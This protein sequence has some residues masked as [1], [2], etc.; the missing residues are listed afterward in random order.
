MQLT[1]YSFLSSRLDHIS[2]GTARKVAMQ[3]ISSGNRLE[4]GKTD[5]GA[6]SASL[7]LRSSQLEMNR[8]MG[9][10]QNA[11][12]FLQT[13]EAAIGS[14]MSI[15]DR[16][17]ELKTLFEDPTKS[18]SDRMFY[19]EEFKEISGQ[20]E[21]LK[22]M[23][24]NK[25]SLFSEIGT[26]QGLYGGSVESF[27]T[28]SESGLS[29]SISRHV[30]D[31][32]DLRYIAEAG[33]AVKRG[34]GGLAV[35]Y[36][37]ETEPK[38][39]VETIAIGGNIAHGDQFSFSI[40]EQTALFKT[41]SDTTFKYL[42]DNSTESAGDPQEVIRDDFYNQ[43]TADA[44][45]MNFLNVAK[46]G[47]NQLALTAKMKG[48]PYLLYNLRNSGTTGSVTNPSTDVANINNDAQED[49]V[50]INIPAGVS[51]YAGDSVSL[52]VAGKSFTYSATA[53]DK[54]QDRIIGMRRLALG[55]ANKIN[56]DASINGDIEA[57]ANLSPAGGTV[58]YSPGSILIHSRDRGAPYAGASAPLISLNSPKGSGTITAI[59]TQ[60]NIVGTAQVVSLVIGDDSTATGDGLIAAGDVYSVTVREL[61]HPDESN[62]PYTSV[63]D[64]KNPLEEEPFSVTTG[65]GWG[66]NDIRN[67]LVTRINAGSSLVKATSGATGEII[68]TSEKEGE[69][70]GVTRGWGTADSLT[71]VVDV[72]N[73]SPFSI[74]KSMNALVEMLSQNGAEQSRLNEAHGILE[75]K[76]GTGEQAI[77]RMT[78]TDFAKESTA[79]VKS[80][81]KF[82]MA[83]K[84]M[85]KA[86]R[87]KD[88]LIPLT[89]NHFRSFVLS[90]TL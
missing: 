40:R 35:V 90:S 77:G 70:F 26:G 68:L 80:S 21:G 89:Q 18:D 3:R 28:S 60:A 48:D 83:T 57:L 79:L 72:P 6:L 67:A 66:A 39:Q 71:K 7:R 27:N 23:D 41:E 17:S 13:Q 84:I 52:Q 37:P 87:L 46:V 55:L 56:N 62:D 74:V 10:V 75:G 11:L 24:F 76:L 54:T 42:A 88:L 32:E 86:I 51:L 12:S 33:E 81:L 38:A 9:N 47:T 19:D 82:E 36:F 2:S 44:N 43:L 25:I 31:F 20:L 14:A 22:N 53:S 30:I 15:L 78:D 8:K 4:N 69:P 64:P 45:I 34:E 59:S 50:Q 1:N 5:A 85:S 73:V 49:L 16:I 61:R 65:S 58:G 29:T 63:N